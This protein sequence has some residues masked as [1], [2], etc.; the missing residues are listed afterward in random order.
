[1]RPLEE[2]RYNNSVKMESD[3]NTELGSFCQRPDGFYDLAQCMQMI[4]FVGK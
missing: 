4:R 3:A 1:M 2:T